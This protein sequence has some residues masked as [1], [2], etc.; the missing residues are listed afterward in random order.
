MI[1]TANATTEEV[2]FTSTTAFGVG[3]DNV[4]IT[5]VVPEPGTWSLL[6]AGIAA[7]AGWRSSSRRP[8]FRSR[9]LSFFVGSSLV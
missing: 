4:S 7:L 2:L 8:T 3:L 9:L 6:G 1:F 5:E